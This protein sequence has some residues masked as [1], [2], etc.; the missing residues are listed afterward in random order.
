MRR[1]PP[2]L[3]PLLLLATAAA[4]EHPNA[5]AGA[6]AHVGVG[7]ASVAARAALRN[8]DF[9]A[10]AAEFG[11]VCGA[12][13]AAVAA[14]EAAAEGLLELGDP[15]G[16]LGCLPPSEEPSLRARRVAVRSRYS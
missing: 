6:A 14:R 13:G 9:A 8:L 5:T 4:V 7:A 16:A 3:P 10:A 15:G 2:L 1:V 12:A 11:A